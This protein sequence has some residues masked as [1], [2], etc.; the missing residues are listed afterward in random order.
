MSFKKKLGQPWN[1]GRFVVGN[2]GQH[3]PSQ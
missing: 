2:L 1:S 3:T